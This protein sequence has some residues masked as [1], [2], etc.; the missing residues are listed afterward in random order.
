[1]HQR[2]IL[3]VA[4]DQ[5]IDVTNVRRFPVC[6]RRKMIYQPARRTWWCRPCNR[7]IDHLQDFSGVY[8]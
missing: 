1:M 5:H 3:P 7:T 8:L 2:V 6:C 4:L